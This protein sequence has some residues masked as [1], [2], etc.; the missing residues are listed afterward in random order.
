MSFLLSNTQAPH[1]SYLEYVLVPSL[2]FYNFKST[3]INSQEH[4]ESISRYYK[5]ME[6]TQTF[7]CH[8]F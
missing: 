8:H 7:L 2:W 6:E 1:T 3:E 4:M 5:S